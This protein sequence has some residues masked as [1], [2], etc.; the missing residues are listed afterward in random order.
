[1]SRAGLCLLFVIG[2]LPATADTDAAIAAG[3]SWLARHHTPVGDTRY[4][5][6]ADFSLRCEGA[7]CV[8][9]SFAEPDNLGPGRGYEAYDVGTTALALLAF[10]GAPQGH[11]AELDG[12]LAW[13]RAGQQGGTWPQAR[14]DGGIYCHALATRALCRS[15][16][17]REHAGT[18]AAADSATAWLLAAQNED[19]G[20]RYVPRE[21]LSDSSVTAQVLMGLA[22]ARDAG[23][24]VPEEALAR[25]RR[26]LARH[27]GTDGRTGYRH[28]SEGRSSYLRSLSTRLGEDMYRP[29][30]TLTAAALHARLVCGE[31]A[32]VW[33]RAPRARL[34]EALPHWRERRYRD[35]NHYYWYLGT[36]ALARLGGEAWDR[37]RPA[38]TEA[39]VASQC[40]EGGSHPDL[41]GSWHPIGE[42][43]Y[44][45]GRVY[46][47]ALA[48]LTLQATR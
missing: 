6:C 16:A 33:T 8:G 22:A 21:G 47:T 39:L 3:L 48:V 46:T 32:G 31:S 34:L 23:L 4:W 11:D 20:W 25:G 14:G 38:V 9:P 40:G 26:L 5:A 36:L 37:W 35:L 12:G 41:A 42:W 45:G 29:R 17:W 19:G 2:A 24:D 18:R 10:L 7:G 13:L 27:T 43:G 44:V 1:M 28:D 30:P 15:L